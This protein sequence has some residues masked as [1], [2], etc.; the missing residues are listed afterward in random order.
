[1]L[2]SEAQCSCRIPEVMLWLS[3][4]PA[5]VGPAPRPSWWCPPLENQVWQDGNPI[6]GKEPALSRGLLLCHGFAYRDCVGSL[7]CGY[8]ASE[9]CSARACALERFPYDLREHTRD[10]CQELNIC[11]IDTWQEAL[12][13]MRVP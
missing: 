3:V 2:L 11:T 13:S 8:R 4:I 7:L 5:R 6:D 9:T 1:M 12:K 10:P